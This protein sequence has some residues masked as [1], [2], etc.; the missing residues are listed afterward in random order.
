MTSSKGREK[1]ITLR[2]DGSKMSKKDEFY[3]EYLKLRR[4]YLELYRAWLDL[5]YHERQI[6]PRPTEPIYYKGKIIL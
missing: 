5:D 6:Y 1:K 3:I 2:K 4:A